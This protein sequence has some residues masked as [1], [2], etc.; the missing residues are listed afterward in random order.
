[1]DSL[2]E[3]VAAHVVVLTNGTLLKDYARALARWPADW[4]HL[5]ISVDGLG[6]NHDRIRGRG[7]FDA[8]VAQLAWLKAKI[9]ALSCV[10]SENIKICRTWW[11][12]PLTYSQSSFIWYFVRRAIRDT[13]EIFQDVKRPTGRGAG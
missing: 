3:Q 11:T 10:T 7:A 6:H 13:R 12:S 8:L 5:Q 1:V 9:A 4:L 2:L